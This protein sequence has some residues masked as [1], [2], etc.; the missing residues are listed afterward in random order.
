MAAAVDV[1]SSGME[2]YVEVLVA[3]VTA[4]TVVIVL[5]SLLVV[6]RVCNTMQG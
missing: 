1:S 6:C 3:G 4:L 2:D 5:V